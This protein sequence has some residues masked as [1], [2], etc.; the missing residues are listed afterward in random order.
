M[1]QPLWALSG[2]GLGWSGL[3]D[4]PAHRS[5]V[6]VALSKAKSAQSGTGRDAPGAILH[7]KLLFSTDKYFTT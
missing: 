5:L 7:Q 6:R 1:S 3:A 2:Q 4:D